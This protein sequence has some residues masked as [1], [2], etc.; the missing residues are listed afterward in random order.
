MATDAVS[1]TVFP[2]AIVLTGEPPEVIA[3]AAVLALA[4]ERT[5]TGICAFTVSAPDVPVMIAVAFPTAAV[6]LAVSVRTLPVE[7]V[8][9]FQAAATPVGSPLIEKLTLPL[10]P[11][12]G[13]T[14]TDVVAVAPGKIFML[15]GT[16]ASANVGPVTAMIMVVDAVIDPQ[17][18]VMVTVEFP[19]IAEPLAVIVIVV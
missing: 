11:R 19:G 9:G 13:I 15:P 17:V 16:A 3:R 14:A 2:H 10:N 4:R 6:L 7:E 18:P 5:F 12:T 1:F 8:L